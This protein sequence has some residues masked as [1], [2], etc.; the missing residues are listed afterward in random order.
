MFAV[1]VAFIILP[2]LLLPIVQQFYFQDARGF[3]N[4]C[5]GFYLRSCH[6]RRSPRSQVSNPVQNVV[7]DNKVSLQNN[8]KMA[9]TVPSFGYPKFSLSEPRFD[10][11]SIILSIWENPNSFHF[12]IARCF[13]GIWS[14]IRYFSAIMHSQIDVS[15]LLENLF[16]TIE[17]LPWCHRS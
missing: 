1:V 5:H 11:V 13:G 10:Q 7:P 6:P 15:I 8:H 3:Q 12:K 16:G 2:C 17:A 4:S 14:V 9:D